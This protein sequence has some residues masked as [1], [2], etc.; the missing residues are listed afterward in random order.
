ME[1][2]QDLL[3]RL[4]VKKSHFEKGT[5]EKFEQK[6]FNLE[7]F[8]TTNVQKYNLRTVKHTCFDILRIFEV[9]VPS[10]KCHYCGSVI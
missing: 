6:D 1:I 5:Q 9:D 7:K 4:S 10:I 8:I 3:N 2:S